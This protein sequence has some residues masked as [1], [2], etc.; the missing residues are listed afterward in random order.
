MP[1]GALRDELEQLRNTTRRF[2]ERHVVPHCGRWRRAGRVDRAVWLEAGRAGLLGA[3]VPAEYGGSGGDFRHEAVICE[4]L[5]RINFIDFGIGVHSGIV[6]PYV[7]RHGTPEQKARWLPMLVSGEMV[8]AIAM[9]EPGAGSDLQA[10]RT[11]ARL[12]GDA[13]VLR[14]QKTFISNGQQADLVLVC[15]RTDPA[16]GGKG[17]SLLGVETG[18]ADGFRRGRNLEKIGLHAQDTSELFFDDVR[19][20]VDAL[21]GGVPGQGFRMMMEMLPQER[22]IIAVQ[23]LAAMEAA[24]A[25]A[26]RYVKERE[27]FGRKLI[28][29]QNTRFK[30]AEARTEATVA[31]AFVERCIDDLVAGRLDAPTAAMAKWWVTDRQ[32][33]VVDECLQLF[34][35]YGY[36]AEY[37]IAQMW[38]DARAQR[39]Y[40]GTNEI[41]KELVAR[42]L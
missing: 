20:P 28:E 12:D 27:A 23:G 31:R 35:G 14:G 37:P 36:M 34:G 11:G 24:L 42:S 8:A 4:E 16:Q 10:M 18:R 29:F 5:A 26:I 25:E 40:G 38:L 19:V 13:Y 41:M 6:V 33:A 2:L 15:A 3:S 1:D 39:I 30:L 32:W 22:L 9:T 17:L 7:V 21:L